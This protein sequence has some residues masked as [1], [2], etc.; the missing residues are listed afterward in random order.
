MGGIFRITMMTVEIRRARTP[1]VRD[2]EFRDAR[3]LLRLLRLHAREKLIRG[4]GA[5][6]S[7]ESVPRMR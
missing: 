1:L 6:S 3:A 7:L 2:G 5:S 4:I